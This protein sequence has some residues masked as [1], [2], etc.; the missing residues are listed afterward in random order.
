MAF[1]KDEVLAGLERSKLLGNKLSRDLP[2]TIIWSAYSDYG[3]TV[4]AIS[5]LLGVHHQQVR[6]IVSH[7]EGKP[8][9]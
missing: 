1:T 9:S 3:I 2:K 6:R 5:R 4:G 7:I 8:V